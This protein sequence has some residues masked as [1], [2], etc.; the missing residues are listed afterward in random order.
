[1]NAV[2]GSIYHTGKV[3]VTVDVP[4]IDLVDLRFVTAGKEQL[5]AVH[6]IFADAAQKAFIEWATEVVA[7]K[8]VHT[9]GI[10]GL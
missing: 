5:I 4:D 2:A 6:K 8:N 1:M 10:I 9:V 7:A 3:T